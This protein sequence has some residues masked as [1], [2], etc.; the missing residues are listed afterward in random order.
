[1]DLGIN[2]KDFVEDYLKGNHFVWIKGKRYFVMDDHKFLMPDRYERDLGIHAVMSVVSHIRNTWEPNTTKMVKDKIKEGMTVVDIGASI[3][4]FTLLLSRCVG[5]TGK[6]YSFEPTPNQFPYLTENI[7]VNGY[8]DRV[9][10]FNIAAWDNKDG[11]KMPPIDKKW[12][13]PSIPVDEVLKDT[14]IDF[15]KIDVDGLEAHVLRGLDRT[16]NLNPDL[17]IMFEYYPRCLIECGE[18]P[19]EIMKMVDK[20]FTHEIIPDDIVPEDGANLWCR[21]K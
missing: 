19:K 4:Y 3:G 9:K 2:Y 12:D 16:F 10:T 18:D 13:C 1:M 7:R 8:S 14:K 20:Y 6:V 15:I 17:Q 21:R 5:K 11:V